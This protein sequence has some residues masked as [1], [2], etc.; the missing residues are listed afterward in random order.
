MKTLKPLLILLIS[1]ALLSC[2]NDDDNNPGSR[3]TEVIDVFI[4]GSTTALDFTATINASDNPLPASSGFTNQFIIDATDRSN[5]SFLF[6]FPPS[7]TSPFTFSTPTSETLSGP[8]SQRLFV[9]GIDFDDAAANSI[10]INYTA[11]GPNANDDLKIDFSGTY[12]E[13]GDP[14]PKTISCFIDIDRD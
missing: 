7:N 10:T 2:G 1:L 5:N 6:R 9:Q 8:I 13:V 14:S 3:S 4:N 12:F 11:F